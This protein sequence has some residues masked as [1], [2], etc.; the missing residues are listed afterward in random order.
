MRVA[1]ESAGRQE[2]PADEGPTHMQANLLQLQHLSHLRY[3]SCGVPSTGAS[4]HACRMPASGAAA[5]AAGSLLSDKII[6]APLGAR[7]T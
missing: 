7:L 4:D 2:G 6:D 3:N 1:C 5:L